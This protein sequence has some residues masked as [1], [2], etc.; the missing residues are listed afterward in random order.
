MKVFFIILIT[1]TVFTESF[2]QKTVIRGSAPGAELKK[3]EINTPSDL[4]TFWEQT[5]ASSMV[6][7]TGNFSLSVDLQETCQ[8]TISIDFHKAELFLEPGKSYDLRIEP[9]R[10][11]EYN[12]V[13][14]FMQAQKL[15]VELADAAPDELNNA[16]G[17]FNTEYSAFLM[18]HF[19]A[20]YR[21]RN[22][23][24]LDTFRI[25]LN[26]DFGSI[27]NP[28]FV[29]YATYKFA[30][31]EQ[32]TKYHNQA[33]LARKYY[34]GVPIL[35]MNP[36]YMDFFN[37][38]FGKYMS[39][40]SNILRKID[41][42]TMIKSPTAYA[43]VMKAMVAD[44]LVKSEQLRELILLK[45]LM[46]FYHTPDYNQN[47]VLAV[48]RNIGEKSKYLENRE[49]SVN[50]INLLTHL[51]PGSPAPE[52]T[53]PDRNQKLMSL[54]SLRGKPIVLNFWTTYCEG[55]LAEMDLLKPLYDKYGGEAH[56][57]SIS[58]DK[59]F[60]KML[61]FINMKSDYVWDFL[62][63]GE[64]SEILKKYDVR[65]YPLFVLIDQDGN[66][67]K[68]PADLPS[69]GLEANLQKLLGK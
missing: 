66:I 27:K 40:S 4:I 44:T 25:K 9:M 55:C 30:S 62:N 58:A 10:Y 69:N 22:K 60:S 12:E 43:S 7:S 8:V 65:S 42:R 16:I 38:F 52:F 20:L 34:S 31:L 61:Y 50:M 28:F 64:K 11:D 15:S 26:Q 19:N 2:A 68:F 18:E 23:A 63:I 17:V 46:E 29:G 47:D 13:D 45:G 51:K 67:Y 56:F 14:P 6:D 24:I 54:K 1:L 57:V 35:Y 21:D 39:S 48:V 41:F 3:I 59:Y 37:A 53:L 32:L 5:L 36:E 49:I 33:Q